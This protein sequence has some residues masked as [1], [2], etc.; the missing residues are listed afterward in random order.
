MFALAFTI[1]SVTSH[2]LLYYCHDLRHIR[3]IY[4]SICAAH[5]FWF[6]YAKACVNTLIAALLKRDIKFKTTEK[7]IMATTVTDAANKA[8]AKLR[9]TAGHRM[10][11]EIQDLWIHVIVFIASLATAIVGIIRLA[12]EANF[13]QIQTISILVCSTSSFQMQYYA[14]CY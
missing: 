2:L 13:K 10:W 7:T 1:Y 9:N 3:S 5:V 6:A 11:M 8:K 14:A 12:G 4:F